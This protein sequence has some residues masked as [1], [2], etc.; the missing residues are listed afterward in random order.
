VFDSSTTTLAPRFPRVR[1]AERPVKPAPITATSAEE[2]NSPVVAAG[3]EVVV[4][5]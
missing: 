4:S 5:Q 1:A 3:I 2:G